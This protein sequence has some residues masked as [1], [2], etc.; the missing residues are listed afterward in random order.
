[1]VVFTGWNIL[2]GAPSLTFRVAID[3]VLEAVRDNQRE[4]GS[5][6]GPAGMYVLN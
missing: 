2:P 5:T 1:V 6:G 3:R 4:G